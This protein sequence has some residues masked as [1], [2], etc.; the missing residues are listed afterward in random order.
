MPTLSTPSWTPSSSTTHDPVPATAIPSSSTHS[1]LPQHPLL[2]SRLLGV[3]LK[4]IIDGGLFKEKETAVTLKLENGRQIIQYTSYKISQSVNPAWVSLKHP[5]PT[6]DN[7]LCIVIKGEHCGKYVRRIHH[8]YDE[9]TAIII[10]GVVKRMKNSVDSLTGEQL[11]LGVDH[12]CEAIETKED[13]KRNKSVM[14]ALRE[15]ARKTRAK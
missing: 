12:L 15:Q 3:Q 13:K 9:E 14:T 10:L 4:V 5:H 6:R 11:E 1:A 8:R 2:D 7:G